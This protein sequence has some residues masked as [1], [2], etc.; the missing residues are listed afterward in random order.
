MPKSLVAAQI[1]CGAFAR[2]QHGPNLGSSPHVGRIKWACDICA[3]HADEYARE[4][5]AEQTTASFEQVC[6]D[7]EVDFIMVATSH[8]VHV[9]I[10]ECA[11]ANG[12]HIY[13]EKPMAMNERQAYDIIRAV[14]RSGVKFCVGYMRRCAPAVVRLKEEWLKH[15]ATPTRQPWRYVETER[16]R[17]QEETCTDFLV[18]VQDESASYRTVHL[19]PF[20]GGGLIIGEAVHWLDLACWLFEQDRPVRLQA[21][22]S[23]RM[24]CGIYLEFQS[25]NAATITV[26]PN[27]SFDYPKEFYEIAHDGAL[28]RSEFYVENQYYGRPGLDREIF[29]LQHDSQPDVGTQGG[30]A[31]F[32]E[33]H[34]AKVEGQVNARLGYEGLRTD[35]GYEKMLAEFLAAVLHDEPVPC[36]ELDGYRATLLGDLAKASIEAGRPLPVPVEKW[37]YHV[38]L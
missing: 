24:R 23:T 27:G 5:G 3:E 32:L 2:A 29:P 35:H 19:D 1:G 16:A 34:R 15:R 8:D 20:R 38:E 12:K 25:G 9:P 36:D 11:T 21:W 30:L 7:P 10:V 26:T 13:C 33:K 6:R 22:G 18:R 37:D 4:C 17:F 31:G 14:R 28:F